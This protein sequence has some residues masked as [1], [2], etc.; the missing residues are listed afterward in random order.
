MKIFYSNNKFFLVLSLLLVFGLFFSGCASQ[1]KDSAVEEAY[2]EIEEPA[3]MVVDSEDSYLEDPNNF[4]EVNKDDSPDLS[5][6]QRKLIK[7]AYL[8]IRT[9]DVDIS[10][11]NVASFVN[12]YEGF[13]T[14]LNRSASDSHV[15]LHVEFGIPTSKLDD[16]LDEIS[17][18]E[19]LD[20]LD[21]TAEDITNSYY[22]STIRLESK[23]KALEKYYSFLEDAEDIED[24]INVQNEIDRLTTDIEALKGQ[25]KLWDS[26]VDYSYVNISFFE[27]Q[28]KVPTD[29]EVTF[30]SM[31]WDDVKYLINSGWVRALSGL[32]SG[33]QWLLIVILISLPI[34]IPLLIILFLIIYLVKRKKKASLEDKEVLINKTN[35][36]D[37][38]EG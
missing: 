30:K 3:E 7:N 25:L 23:E 6:V 36:K 16:F 14:N 24:L 13:E 15:S 33:L 18:N 20:Y 19:D 2:P 35:D 8:E 38:F 11:E 34:I 29:R 4:L 9:D 5:S 32:V 17:A 37:N 27:Y 28:D 1:S 26:Q 10:Y 31:S 21:V 12:K 22:D